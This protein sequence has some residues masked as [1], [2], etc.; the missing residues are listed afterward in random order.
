VAIYGAAFGAI[1]PLRASTMA[2]QFGRRSFGAITAAS[3]IPVAVAASAGPLAAG[4]LYDRLGSYG[5]A[6]AMAAGALAI[7]ALCVALTPPRQGDLVS[8]AGEPPSI[9]NPA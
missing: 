7:S 5:P 4:I 3:G 8:T 1:S 9:V 6:L 2:D